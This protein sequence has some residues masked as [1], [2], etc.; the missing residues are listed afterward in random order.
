[1]TPLQVTPVLSRLQ[2][3]LPRFGEHLNPDI[4]LRELGLDSMD[5]VELLC[6]IHEEFEVSLT[7]AEFHPD[8]TLHDLGALIAA[9]LNSNPS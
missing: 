6:A 3:R 4:P 5:T 8:A 7:Q 1:M 2:Q 9:K